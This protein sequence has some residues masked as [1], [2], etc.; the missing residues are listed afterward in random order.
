MYIIMWSKDEENDSNVFNT[1]MFIITESK[2]RDY[3]TV[4]DVIV[5]FVVIVIF[6][7]ITVSII[8]IISPEAFI[9]ILQEQ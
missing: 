1:H 5:V 4:C 8:I 6:I 2:F 7:I 9:T 3:N